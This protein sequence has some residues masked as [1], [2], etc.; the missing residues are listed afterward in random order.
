M[1]TRP[2]HFL[3]KVVIHSVFEFIPAQSCWQ[4]VWAHR[5]GFDNFTCA[6]TWFKEHYGDGWMDEVW[7]VIS[8][9]GWGERY[10]DPL[11]AK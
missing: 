10:F 8:W 3:G 11:V 1:I 7:T 4:S 6:D 9:P 2:A 5:D